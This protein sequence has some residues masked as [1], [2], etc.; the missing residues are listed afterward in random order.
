MLGPDGLDVDWEAPEVE[1]GEEEGE[2]QVKDTLS[3]ITGRLQLPYSPA[4]VTD[5]GNHN[6]FLLLI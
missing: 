2:R 6:L 4:N 1:I 3:P 5:A